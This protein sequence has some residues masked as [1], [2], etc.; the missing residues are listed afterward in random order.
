VKR[1][2]A[3]ELIDLGRDHYTLDEYRDCLVQLGRIAHLFG[4]FRTT[5]NLLD[6]IGHPI[7]S[8][9]DVGCGGGQ[10]AYRLA[11]RYPGASV[12]AIDMNPDAIDF[13]KEHYQL[14]N[15]TFE[16]Q[17]EKRLSGSY[18]LVHSSLVCHHIT[19]DELPLFVQEMDRVCTGTIVI[20]DL[21]RSWIAWG[22][23][24]LSA[25]LLFRNRLITHDGLL[26]IRRSFVRA[27]WRHLEKA[28]GLVKRSWRVFARPLY[29]WGVLIEQDCS[30]GAHS[31]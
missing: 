19:C 1:S 21:R 30:Y 15:L 13:A 18:D 28:S 11:K 22:L 5:E 31:P 7:R 3:L 16:V 20:N 2:S 4:G 8:I 24:L 14:P 25:P 17:L 10:A 12:V 6:K 27:D 23:Y 29:R 9:L 26:S